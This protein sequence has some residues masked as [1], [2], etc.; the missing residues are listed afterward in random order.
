M[1]EGRPGRFS[2]VIAKYLDRLIRSEGQSKMGEEGTDSETVEQIKG[3]R[4]FRS[5]GLG[6][7][8]GMERGI[9][10]VIGGE[11]TDSSYV[12]KGGEKDNQK[13]QGDDGGDGDGDEDGQNKSM[14]HTRS[15]RSAMPS[16]MRRP[17]V[18]SDLICLTLARDFESKLNEAFLLFHVAPGKDFF[19]AFYRRDLA[20]RLLSNIGF[21]FSRERKVVKKIEAECGSGFTMHIEGMLKDIEM[22]K[23]INKAYRAAF[24]D[25][26]VVVASSSSSPSSV[27]TSRLFSLRLP[28]NKRKASEIDSKREA[29]KENVGKPGVVLPLSLACPGITAKDTFVHV[30]TSGFWPVQNA[31]ESFNVPQNLMALESHFEA[32]YL[33]RYANRKLL[34]LRGFGSCVLTANFPAARKE[35][36]GSLSQAAILLLFN[37]DAKLSYAEIRKLT[38]LNEKDLRWILQGLSGSKYPILIRNERFRLV[39]NHTFTVNNDFKNDSYQIRIQKALDDAAAEEDDKRR[40]REE[41]VVD[42]GQQIEAAIVRIVKLR[43]AIMHEDLIAA[44]TAILRFPAA[45]ADIE[46]YIDSLISREYFARGGKDKYIYLP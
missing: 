35:L 13:D 21:S 2:E 4:Q 27:P 39:D 32:F 41:V 6:S 26:S 17:F 9:T 40:M 7:K 38:N 33:G 44:L 23:S 10:T 43:R 37:G 36:I 42:R 16:A 31:L 19:E 3:K 20:R 22:S 46:K 1:N 5:R 45:L 8:E 14:S 18:K 24:N 30:I 28:L 15:D 29:K 25:A 34:W 12:N 11:K